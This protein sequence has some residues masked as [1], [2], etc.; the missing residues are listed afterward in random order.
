MEE[1]DEPSH[2]QDDLAPLRISAEKAKRLKIRQESIVPTMGK[3]GNDIER[4]LYKGRSMAVFT[5]GG[6]SQGIIH[7][8]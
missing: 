3:E 4:L 5:S 1:P 7:F 6:D 2:L 8:T